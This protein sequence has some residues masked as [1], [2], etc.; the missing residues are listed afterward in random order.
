ME[1]NFGNEL[2]NLHIY[3][4]Y[5]LNTEKKFDTFGGGFAAQQSASFTLC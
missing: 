1:E 4:E 3:N 2:L 5:L